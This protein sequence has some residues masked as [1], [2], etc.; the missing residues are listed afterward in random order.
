MQSYDELSC[1]VD[2]AIATVTLQRPAALNAITTTMLSELADALDRLSE[3]PDVVVVVLTGAGRAF[4]AGVDLKSLGA[5]TLAQGKVGDV[6]DVPA[7]AV[8]ERITAMGQ[9]VVA[10]VNGPC[11]TGALELALACDL[12]AVASEAPIGDTHARFGLRPTWAMSARLPRAVGPQAAKLL[13]YTARTITGEDAMRLGMAALCVP[14]AE[15]DAAVDALVAEI[16][17]NS[18]GSLAA[19]KDLYRQTAGRSLQEAIAYEYGT[20]YDIADTES[21]LAPWR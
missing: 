4:S 11:F 18:A 12:M 6:L 3:R 10:K 9:I 8:T 19:Y 1:V 7:R 17:A 2:G 21:R 15:L 14:R 13:S 20:D 5:R 16:V